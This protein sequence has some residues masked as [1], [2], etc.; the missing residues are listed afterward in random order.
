MMAFFLPFFQ[1][2]IRT[3]Q[4]VTQIKSQETRGNAPIR[5]RAALDFFI[6]HTLS[7]KG[8][9]SSCSPCLTASD[10]WFRGYAIGLHPFSKG[11]NRDPPEGFLILETLYFALHALHCRVIP[12]VATFL[13]LSHLQHAKSKKIA[14]DYYCPI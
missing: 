3:Y 8:T 4:S 7:R 13:A 10:R 12:S 9:A 11:G 6:Y 1:M 2:L 5:R 14:S